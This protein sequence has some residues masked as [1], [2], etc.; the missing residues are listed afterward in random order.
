MSIVDLREQYHRRVCSEIVRVRKSRGAIK[1]PNFADGNNR[2]SVAVAWG[3]L[4]QLGCE[5]GTG[6]LSAQTIGGLFEAI[7]KDFLEQTFQ[8]LYHLRPGSWLYTTEDTAIAGFKQYEHLARLE[9]IVSRDNDLASAL[10]GDYIVKPDIV[11]GRYPVPDVEINTDEVLVGDAEAVASLSPLRE[12]NQDVVRPILHAS[13]SCKWTIRSDRA[14]NTRTEALN[15]IR[16]RKGPLPHVAAV[17]AEP[18]P[19]RLATLA[20]GTGDLDCVYHFALPELTR[21]IRELENVDQLDMLNTLVEG[22]R[23][24]DISDLPLDLAI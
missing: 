17:T 1:Y 23:L 12:A 4:G 2:S 9:R 10:G 6:D 7:T 20:L 14:Q 24:R 15:L 19:T 16:N 3:I 13:V 8:H 11:V 21:A 5:P 22:Q 18:L